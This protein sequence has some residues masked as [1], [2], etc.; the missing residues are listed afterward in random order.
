MKTRGD[1]KA[2]IIARWRRDSPPPSPSSLSLYLSSSVCFLSAVRVLHR[3]RG[4]KGE[5]AMGENV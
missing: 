1:G 4:E 3:H 5:V 2:G